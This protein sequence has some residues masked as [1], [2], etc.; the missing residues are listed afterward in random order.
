MDLSNLFW[1]HNFKNL[2]FEKIW[3][4]SAEFLQGIC[5]CMDYYNHVKNSKLELFLKIE[6]ASNQQ[7]F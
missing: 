5:I 6:G 7:I 1:E 2:Y 4:L 3:S